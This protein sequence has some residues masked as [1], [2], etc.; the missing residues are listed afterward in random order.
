MSTASHPL[1]SSED[2]AAIVDSAAM[3]LRPCDRPPFLEEVGAELSRQP[4]LGPGLVYR[5]ARETQR[6]FFDPPGLTHRGARA[7]V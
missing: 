7:G 2:L 5:I 1:P 3:P 6:R 4:T